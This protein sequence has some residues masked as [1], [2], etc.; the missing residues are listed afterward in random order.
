MSAWPSSI[1]TTR[2]SAPWFSRCVAKAWRKTCGDSGAWMSASNAYFF[3]NCQNAWRDMASARP[4]MNSA[5]LW[6]PAASSRRA[7]FRY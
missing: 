2:R 4:V 3:T 6:R 7:V 1:C 5:S